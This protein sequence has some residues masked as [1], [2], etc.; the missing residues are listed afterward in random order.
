M[1]ERQNQRISQRTPGSGRRLPSISDILKRIG[2]QI[3]NR[4][5]NEQDNKDDGQD[6]QS[7]EEFAAL[8]PGE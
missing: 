5:S 2:E 6:E 3:G 8:T 4:I 7:D 1:N